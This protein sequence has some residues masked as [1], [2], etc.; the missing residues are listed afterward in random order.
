MLARK[1]RYHD[2]RDNV[3]KHPN[4]DPIKEKP[5]RF[6]LARNGAHPLANSRIRACMSPSPENEETR[7]GPNTSS[8]PQ[9]L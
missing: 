3:G 1:Y 6:A 2:R 8:T 9:S 5:F 4:A 7:L